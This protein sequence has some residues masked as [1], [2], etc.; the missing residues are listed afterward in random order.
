M[1][2]ILRQS[3]QIK[4]VLG[5]VVSVSDGF[6]PVTNL[7]LSTADEAEIIKSDASGVTD[8]AGATF[9]AISNA[10]GY[11]NL[12]LTTAF[13]DTV[14]ILTVLVNDDSLC[15]PV[16]ATFQVVEEAVFDALYASGAGGYLAAG[17]ENA[18]AD[19]I[20]SRNVSNVE[21]SA[22]EHTLC[23]IVL[24]CLEYEVTGT[25]WTIKRTDG[26]TTHATKTL[27]TNAAAEPVTE[28]T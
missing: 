20:L 23:T 10:D 13:T 7:D 16:K 1:T 25:T 19:A 17:G 22:G 12:T 15:L 6:T 9:A 2:Q 28:I 18:I 3:T 4:V 11:Y 24:A 5:P 26:S 14:G 21:G 8:I 27:T